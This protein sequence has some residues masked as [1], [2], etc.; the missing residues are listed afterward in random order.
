MQ[1]FC[2]RVGTA[3]PLFLGTHRREFITA[4]MSR[5]ENTFRIDYANVPKKPSYDDL[6]IFIAEQLGLTEDQVLRIQCSRTSSCA[7]VKVCELELAQRV[8]E[9]HDNKHEIVFDGKAY[10]L[11]IRMEDGAVEVKLYDLTENVA[12]QQ[13]E[14]FLSTYGEI[15]N[16][17]EQM[18][19]EKKRFPGK[20][21]GVWI[22]RMLV[23]ENI[24]SYV[25][26]DGETTYVSYYGQHQ[27]CRYCEEFVHNGASCVQNKKL[28]IQKLSA[29]KSNHQSY[30]KV[31]KQ[32]PGQKKQPGSAASTS[33]SSTSASRSTAPISG[34]PAL[35]T[36]AQAATAATAAVATLK[37]PIVLLK[38]LPLENFK[39]PTSVPALPKKQP[40]GTNKN[41]HTDGNETDDSMASSGSSKSRSRSGKKA[42]YN[43]GCTEEGNQQ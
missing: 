31:T 13:I 41:N 12:K 34:T 39:T 33:S 32:K 3:G 43:V 28:L 1:S 29:D 24:P 4:A 36:R 16:T 10:K 40:D 42:R 35:N 11:P 27:T 19:D 6:H 14:E 25:K 26:I 9:Q 2:L 37:Q 8:V 38:P 20:P 7:F 22:S 17:Y 30:A 21:T 18:W 5:R 23:K 15:L